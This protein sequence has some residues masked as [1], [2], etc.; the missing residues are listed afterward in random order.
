MKILSISLDRELLQLRRAVLEA[1]EHDVASIDSE[2]EALQ[3]VQSPEVF[4][5]VLICHRFPDAAARQTVRLVRQI[6]PE[7]RI[8]Y[9]AHRYG[10]WPEVEADRYIVGADGGE[11]LFRVL[12]EVHA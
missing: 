8:V 5:V 10:E 7:T 1:A 3:L 6:H 11:A 9:I 2:K 12:Q 4:D